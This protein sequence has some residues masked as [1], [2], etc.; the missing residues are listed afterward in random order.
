MTIL[1]P[2]L[3]KGMAL[4]IGLVWLAYGLPFL[5]PILFLYHDLLQRMMD[6]LNRLL[7]L[8]GSLALPVLIGLIVMIVVSA[9][10]KQVGSSVRYLS[11]FLIPLLSLPWAY[12]VTILS[13]GQG[14]AIVLQAPFNQEVILID[15]AK[16]SAY[17]YVRSFLDAQG[18]STISSM[19]ITHQDNDHSGNVNRILQDYHV[20]RSVITSTD[21]DSAWFHLKM[22]KTTLPDPDNNQGSLVTLLQL[23][24]I[25]FLFMADVDA[26]VEADL[27]KQYPSLEVDIL[28]VGHHGSATS[29]SDFFLSKI[30]ARLAMISVGYNRYGHPS[31]QTLSR[32]RAA[33][34]QIMTTQSEGDIQFVFFDFLT[35][36]QTSSL[37]LKPLTLGF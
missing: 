11:S 33:R 6:F 14:D 16:A 23:K 26:L 21:L 1:Y 32:L 24:G 13:V 31:P 37:K 29:T 7:L 27:I 4:L 36:L 12:Q 5:N 17:T 18:I 30:H 35:G 10:W 28:K 34:V 9:R 8:R 15:T 25:R 20:M 3:K 19:I 2:I 22:L